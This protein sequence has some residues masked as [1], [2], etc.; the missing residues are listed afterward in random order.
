MHFQDFSA[1]N[2]RSKILNTNLSVV[3][4]V[5]DLIQRNVYVRFLKTIVFVNKS[6][7]YLFW[8]EFTATA[9][10]YNN[11]TFYMC[12]KLQIICDFPALRWFNFFYIKLKCN[13]LYVHSEIRFFFHFINWISKKIMLLFSIK[14]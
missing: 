2:T 1:I 3:C 5:Y 13:V 11:E 7:F 4:K 8:T 10:E 9:L 6:W 12:L 14:Y